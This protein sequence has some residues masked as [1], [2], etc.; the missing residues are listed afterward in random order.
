MFLIFFLNVLYLRRIKDSRILK[1]EQIKT[2]NNQLKQWKKHDEQ[3]DFLLS[4]NEFEDCTALLDQIELKYGSVKSARRD[5]IKDELK[6]TRDTQVRLVARTMAE[7][8]DVS[9]MNLV[10]LQDVKNRFETLN[11]FSK[12]F[13]GPELKLCLEKLGSHQIELEKQIEAMDSRKRAKESYSTKKKKSRISVSAELKDEELDDVFKFDSF[14]DLD[15]FDFDF[16]K[17]K[18]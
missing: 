16:D 6:R 3:L 12:K 11:G 7:L 17:K 18:K 13:V 9:D 1:P 10:S 2:Y 14:E 8:D 15:D 5:Q 4:K